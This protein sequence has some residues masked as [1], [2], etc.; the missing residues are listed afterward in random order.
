MHGGCG[1]IEPPFPTSVLD[2]Y[3]ESSVCLLRFNTEEAVPSTHWALE[4]LLA[5][6][7]KERGIA[8]EGTEP[9]LYNEKSIPIPTEVSSPRVPVLQTFLNI[10]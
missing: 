10:L 8:S 5:L 1:S 9:Q 4:W 2:G 3:Q 7:N 6:R